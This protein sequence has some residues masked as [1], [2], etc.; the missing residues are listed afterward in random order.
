MRS[1][2]VGRGFLVVLLLMM[3]GACSARIDTTPQRQTYTPPPPRT[4]SV[5][6]EAL[7]VRN[8]P[9]GKAKI[10]GV[11]H[12]HDVVE[13]LTR[14]DNWIQVK[15][16]YNFMGWVYG[17]YITG[18]PDIRPVASNKKKDTFVSDEIGAEEKAGSSPKGEAGT[19]VIPKKGSE[20]GIDDVDG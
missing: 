7:N 14:K 3:L 6:A 5:T 19:I 12:Q 17:A 13:I 18:F 16:P 20:S 2:L 11:V 10:I 4:E 9:S 8:E 15:T 1:Y